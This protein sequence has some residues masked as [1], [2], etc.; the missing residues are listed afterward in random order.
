MKEFALF[1]DGSVNTQTKIGFGA[2]VLLEQN[3]IRSL[4]KETLLA[5]IK[6]Q[7]FDS[8]SSTKL[9]LQILLYALTAIKK[10]KGIALLE[11]NLVLFTDSQGVVGLPGRRKKL[12][13]KNYIS[14]RQQKELNNADLYRL[15]FQELDLLHFEIIQLKGHTKSRDRDDIQQIFS[16]I[17]QVARKALSNF[18]K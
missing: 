5:K 17:D 6:T 18:T 12:E 7:Q 11:N 15:F 1:T 4:S 13:E 14:A 8:T 9:E 2:Y 10:E 3:E 16:Q